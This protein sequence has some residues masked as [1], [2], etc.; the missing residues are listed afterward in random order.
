M[1]NAVAAGAAGAA[2]AGGAGVAAGTPTINTGGATAAGHITTS[3]LLQPMPIP[4]T[5]GAPLFDGHYVKDFLSVLEHHAAVA[6]VQKSELPPMVLQYC[7][8]EVKR[9][10]RFCDELKGTDWDDVRA[11]LEGLYGSSD[12]PEPVKWEDLMRFVKMSKTRKEFTKRAEVDRYH[13]SYLTIANALKKNGLPPATKTYVTT[14]LPDANL[15]TNSLPTIAQMIRIIRDR[16]D[17]KSVWSY[18]FDTDDDD[19][20]L[21]DNS[22]PQLTVLQSAPI[23][24]PIPLASNTQSRTQKPANDIDA[25]TQQLQQLSLNQ[26]QMMNMVQGLSSTSNNSLGASNTDKRCFICNK[27]GTHRLHPRHCPE[28]VR[29]L[30]EGLIRFDADNNR[31]TMPDGSNLPVV[32]LTSGG[33]AQ[34]LRDQQAS[35]NQANTSQGMVH[36][37]SGQW[38]FYKLP[39]DIKYCV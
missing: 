38:H 13:Q 34:F 31:Y 20:M 30:N 6:G 29:L 22:S 2:I 4:R 21:G 33:V 32:P 39:E 5:V 27:T 7:A 12:E 37:S 18:G 23:T 36:V 15:N 26:A 35:K 24:E 8:E 11:L 17:P 14:R 10:V 9:V 25:I 19:P 1:S 3:I 16:F 28:T